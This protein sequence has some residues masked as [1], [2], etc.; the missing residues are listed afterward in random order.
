M[1]SVLY[2]ICLLLCSSG[3]LSYEGHR[4][5]KQSH[6]DNIERPCPLSS[7]TCI[8][9]YFQ[10]KLGCGPLGEHILKPYYLEKI[11]ADMPHSNAS[12]RFE[13]VRLHGLNT[14]RITE[15]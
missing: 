2:L 11:T 4:I 5:S 1:K 6:N 13:G 12:V 7:M 10:S 3:T 8:R 9:N 15:F 14:G